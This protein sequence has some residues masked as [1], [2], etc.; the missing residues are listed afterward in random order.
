[1]I[2][3]LW[4]YILSLLGGI[5]LVGAGGI[6]ILIAASGSRSRRTMKL[7]QGLLVCGAVLLVLHVGVFR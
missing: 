5:L 2:V 4:L 6:L 3:G 7:G 1:M